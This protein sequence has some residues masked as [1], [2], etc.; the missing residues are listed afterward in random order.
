MSRH[1]S[2]NKGDIS[3]V[4]KED[5]I[6]L[7]K[8]TTALSQQ[9]KI[10]KIWLFG[11]SIHNKQKKNSDIDIAIVSEAFKK[12]NSFE[13][14]VYLGKIAWKTKATKIE[15]L[16]FTPQ[17][18]NAPSKLSFAWEIKKTGKMLFKNGHFNSKA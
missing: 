18:M 16:G 14:L 12:M 1:V 10:D 8:F 2:K 3:M 4:K 5:L 17:E 9:V 11:S 6:L 13:R 15:A 7:K